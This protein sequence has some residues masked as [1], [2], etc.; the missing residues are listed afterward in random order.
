MRNAP[1]TPRWVVLG[2]ADE[3]AVDDLG[4]QRL[5]GPTV[6]LEDPPAGLGRRVLDLVKQDGLAGATVG[7]Q[8]CGPVD[9]GLERTGRRAE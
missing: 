8:V 3:A 5:A 4:A 7:P 9:V 2:E 6:L 1:S